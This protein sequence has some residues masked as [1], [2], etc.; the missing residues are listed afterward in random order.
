MSDDAE[1]ALETLARSG[2]PS[3]ALARVQR[4]LGAEDLARETFRA[5]ATRLG[6]RATMLVARD[7]LPRAARACLQAAEA[8][9]EAGEGEPAQ[10]VAADLAPHVVSMPPDQRARLG[11]VHLRV[12]DVDTARSIWATVPTSPAASAL[13]AAIH[14]EGVDQA[15]AEL[16][17]AIRAMGPEDAKPWA[18]SAWWDVIGWLGRR[19]NSS[20]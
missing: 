20:P 7:G 16:E 17:A 6:E 10:R 9:V 5:A 1:R 2:R 8:W 15:A 14:G 13:E 4:Y 12:G 18:D 11:F 3:T 19:Q